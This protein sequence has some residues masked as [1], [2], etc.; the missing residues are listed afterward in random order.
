ML[1]AVE[2]ARAFPFFRSVKHSVHVELEFGGGVELSCS[3]V[4]HC[5]LGVYSKKKIV[6]SLPLQA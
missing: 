5:T 1:C 3:Q 2:R 4:N 6:E